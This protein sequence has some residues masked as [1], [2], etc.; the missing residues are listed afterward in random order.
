[1]IDLLGEGS[2]TAAEFQRTDIAATTTIDVSGVSI[3]N[4]YYDNTLAGTVDIGQPIS[5]G[6]Q[7]V[8]SPAADSHGVANEVDLELSGG[9]SVDEFN[10]ILQSYIPVTNNT[11][12]INIASGSELRIAFAAGPEGGENNSGNA[13]VVD[14]GRA[15]FENDGVINV[16]AGG[17]L[18]AFSNIERSEISGANATDSAANGASGV[19]LWDA[20]D[21][22]GQ[23]NIQ[24]AA[25][26]V[27][28][29]ELQ[30]FL[31]GG[32]GIALNGGNQADPTKT[33]LV[34]DAIVDDQTIVDTG[35]TAVYA[36][37]PLD[38]YNRAIGGSFTFAGT[39]GILL[40]DPSTPTGGQGYGPP[41]Y[42]LNG[43]T[44]TSTAL[45]QPF[46]VPIYGFHQGDTI[47]LTTSN[48]QVDTYS[49]QP[50]WNGATGTLQV[51][52]TDTNPA[53]GVATSIVAQFNLV[54][55]YA[56][57]DFAASALSITTDPVLGGYAPGD[58]V[59]I[60]LTSDAP[61]FVSGTR[62]LTEQGERAVEDLRPGD[63]VLTHLGK[64]SPVTWIGHRT[65]DL[66]RHPKRTDVRPIRIQAGAFG[67]HRPHR[68]L[69]LSPDH[70][71]FVDDVLI[72][73]RYLVNDATIRPVLRERVTYWHIELAAHD[74]LMAEG[75]P[76]ESYLDTGNRGAFINGGPAVDIHP[77]FAWRIWE[78]K[79]CAPL[80][81]DGPALDAVRAGLLTQ[82]LTLGHVMTND[83]DLHV[84]TESQRLVCERDGAGY[85]CL[86]PSDVK[87]LRLISRS[88]VPAHVRLD[89]NDH[90]RLGVAISRLSLDGQSIALD[91]TRLC[92]GWHDLENENTEMPWRWTSGDAEIEADGAGELV[93]RVVMVGQ[94]WEEA[95]RDASRTALRGGRK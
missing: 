63:R 29:V 22:T 57:T 78:A 79:G 25:G 49:F 77:D 2:A 15:A 89:T 90:R 47:A 85:R 66:A 37:E 23:I 61:C 76:C 50:L 43:Q 36:A 11:G 92:A 86:L 13:F 7:T 82:A 30:G 34:L 91:D 46:G 12:T 64:S 87:T 20:I 59:E 45:D 28:S 68:D 41:G 67:S 27:T 19:F 17:T 93:F 8:P 65:I 9:G 39:G 4:T 72:P 75:L 94:Y 33:E 31:T 40:V 55:N 58:L 14:P 44:V 53:G 70:S 35:A 54:G 80:V 73:V 18:I 84:V 26:Q 16:Q 32:G 62:I 38:N 42:V 60:T 95:G 5:L 69:F 83:P 6:G 51:Q 21:N 52:E 1:M 71:V 56:A 48:L 10:F 74:V 88:A 81:L 3:W 24:G